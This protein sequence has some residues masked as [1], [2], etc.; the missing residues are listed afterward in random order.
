MMYEFGDAEIPW[1]PQLIDVENFKV[2]SDDP[3]YW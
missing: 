2:K 3:A 1:I